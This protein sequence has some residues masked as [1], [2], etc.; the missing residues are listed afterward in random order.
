MRVTSEN[1]DLPFELFIK[2][3]VDYPR[4]FFEVFTEIHKLGKPNANHF[5][6]SKFIEDGYVSEVLTTN[7]D[8]QITKNIN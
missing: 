2:I 5:L 4:G 6:V 3:L 8:T 1:I 7:F